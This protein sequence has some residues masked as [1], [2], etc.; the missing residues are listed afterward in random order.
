M[1]RGG[2]H[3]DVGVAGEVRVVDERRDE[4][5]R[6]C[7]RH[8]QPWQE[9]VLRVERQAVGVVLEVVLVGLRWRDLSLAPGTDV[10]ARLDVRRRHVREVGAQREDEDMLRQGRDRRGN[11][12]GVSRPARRRL[13][14]ITDD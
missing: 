12:V 10:R 5:I 11:L 9:A 2:R 7:R 14:S 13:R 1:M 8:R 6:R 3:G 4:P